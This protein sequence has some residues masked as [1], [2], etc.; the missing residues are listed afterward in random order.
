MPWFKYLDP[1]RQGFGVF[2]LTATHAQYDW[3]YVS[4]RTDPQATLVPGPSWRTPTGTNKLEAPPRSGP[5]RRS[6]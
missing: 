2:D 3:F 4:D 1:D 6:S 5:D